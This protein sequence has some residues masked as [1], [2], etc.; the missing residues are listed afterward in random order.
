MCPWYFVR[1]AADAARCPKY[2]REVDYWSMGIALYVMLS[3]EAPFEQDQP[4]ED[5]LAEVTAGKVSTSSSAWKRVSADARALVSGLLTVDPK[6]RM[7]LIQMRNHPWLKAELQKLNVAAPAAA[8]A[9]AAPPAASEIEARLDA[10]SPRPPPPRLRKLDDAAAGSQLLSASAVAAVAATRRSDTP[11]TGGGSSL[12]YAP[13]ALAAPAHAGGEDLELL[14]ALAYLPHCITT[15]GLQLS[16]DVRVVVMPDPGCS[17]AV[18]THT[19]RFADDTVF[20]MPGRFPKPRATGACE[21]AQLLLWLAGAADLALQAT[22]AASQI[23]LL[24]FVDGFAPDAAAFRSFCRERGIA[25][26][27]PNGS[28][29]YDAPPPAAPVAAAAGSEGSFNSRHL[30]SPKRGTRIAVR[31]RPEAARD[32]VGA[33]RPATGDAARRAVAD[34]AARRAATPSPPVRRRRRAAGSPRACR[35]RAAPARA[36]ASSDRAAP[37]ASRRCDCVVCQYN[38]RSTIARPHPA[39]RALLRLRPSPSTPSPAPPS[40]TSPCSTCSP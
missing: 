1:T 15:A 34:A 13:S 35:R 21:R 28:R 36:A 17:G 30:A 19:I 26:P 10:R 18:Q 32:A 20:V 14:A 3:G 22:E 16:G 37:G 39:H 25:P 7:G 5:L 31:T 29:Q 4:T 33:S 40:R 6:R 2:G 8:A 9:A 12:P 11:P 23:V 38:S 27:S 24:K